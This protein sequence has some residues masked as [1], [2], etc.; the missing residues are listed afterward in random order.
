MD[1]IKYKNRTHVRL[2]K[3]LK[4]TLNMLQ[5]RDWQVELVT[6]TVIPNELADHHNSSACVSYDINMLKAIIF[7]NT[8]LCKE[9]NQDPL[10]NLYHEVFHIWLSYCDEEE[11]QCNI[12]ATLLI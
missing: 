8:A 9:R 2:E 10:W 3:A 6:G 1:N 7:I 4:S 12:L 11:R 5:M